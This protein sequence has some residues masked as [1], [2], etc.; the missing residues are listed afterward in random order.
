MNGLS[1]DVI[2]IIDRYIVDY[3]YSALRCQYRNIWLGCDVFYWDRNDDSFH[4]IKDKKYIANYRL[5]T[6]FWGYCSIYNFYTQLRTGDVPK[7][8]TNK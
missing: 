4:R 3:L 1:N 8:Y 6:R 2:A 5:L 7:K